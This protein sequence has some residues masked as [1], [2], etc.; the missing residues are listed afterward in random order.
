MI[1]IRFLCAV[2][3]I[4]LFFVP[5]SFAAT[6]I[7]TLANQQILD[8]AKEKTEIEKV[9]NT[10]KVDP[11]SFLVE[12]KDNLDRKELINVK[13]PTELKYGDA[14]KVIVA[15]SNVEK[16]LLNGTDLA[17][18]LEQAP[19]KWEVPVIYQKELQPVASF[20]IDYFNGAWQIVEIGGYLSPKQS[21]LSSDSNE[22]TNLW[23]N[24]LSLN[25]ADSFFHF[26]SLSLHSDFLYLATE[27]QEYFIPLLHARDEL[28]GLKN[29][30]IYTRDELVSAIG[31]IIKENAGSNLIT[32]GYPSLGTNSTNSTYPSNEKN[33]NKFPII[34]LLG[35][36]FIIAVIY[37]YRKIKLN[38]K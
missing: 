1:K 33:I 16:A 4:T 14:Y 25:T 10:S 32:L 20:T 11:K 22:L 3:F 13:S 36:F 18:V 26:R 34:F 27:E 23:R 12:E 29:E 31:P 6:T 5:T 9:I 7:E 21:Y 15:D 2:I 8:Q 30:E 35:I 28:Y 17:I 37:G 19:Y 24:K 38:A